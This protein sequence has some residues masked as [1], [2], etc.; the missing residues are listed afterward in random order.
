MQE[1]VFVESGA[2]DRAARA[3][4]LELVGEGDLKKKEGK[5]KEGTTALSALK[6]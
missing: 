1:A 6:V 2:S 3:L 4:R 5:K